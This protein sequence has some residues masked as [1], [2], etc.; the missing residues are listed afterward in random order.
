MKACFYFKYVGLFFSI[1]LGSLRLSALTQDVLDAAVNQPQ[2][3]GQ[4]NDNFHRLYQGKLDRKPQNIIPKRDSTYNLGA[5]GTEWN[6]LYVDNIVSGTAFSMKNRLINGDMRI[7]QRYVAVSTNPGTGVEAYTLDRWVLGYSSAA[8]LS[9]QKVTDGPTGFTTSLK[10]TV[11]T[12]IVMVAASEYNLEQRIE[13]YNFEDFGF[14]AAGAS[15]VT[16]SFYV[17]CSSA[18][19]FAITLLNATKNRSYT[20]TYTINTAS[21]WEQKSITFPGDTTGT[22]AV[23]TSTGAIVRFGLGTGST[24]EGT[25]GTWTANELNGTSA[26]FDLATSTNTTWQITGVQLEVGA[27]AT[28]FERRMFSVELNLA[29][30]YFEKSYAIGTTLGT[31]TD[32]GAIY[33]VRGTGSGN[34]SVHYLPK[35]ISP[36]IALYSPATG[37]VARVRDLNTGADNAAASSSVSETNS[38]FSTGAAAGEACYFHFTA[39]AEL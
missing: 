31:A 13:G 8:R 6:T 2:E 4:I 3:V 5:S 32:T 11:S 21:T 17:K 1:G 9:A 38:A 20:T 15:S 28:P 23:G 10:V 24:F 33:I 35:R 26:T 34:S 16:L 37:T 22:W 7:S 39:D 29:M 25:A 27:F 14:G 18:G 30:R 12:G 19:T 36:T